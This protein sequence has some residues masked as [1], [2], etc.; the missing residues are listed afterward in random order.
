MIFLIGPINNLENNPHSLATTVWA[1]AKDIDDLFA[2]MNYLKQ[3][4]R[5]QRALQIKPERYPSVGNY[6]LKKA[7]NGVLDN[8]AT[9]NY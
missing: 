5:K 6:L 7:T 2:P 4:G 8:A 3:I 1:P 9:P